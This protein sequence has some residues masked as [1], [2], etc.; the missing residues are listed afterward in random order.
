MDLAADILVAGGGMS[1]T[2]AAIAAARAGADVLLV[3]RFGFLGGAA[4]AAAV[5]QFVGWDTAAGRRVVA[6]LAEEVVARLQALGASDGH[7]HFTMSTGHRMDRVC[8]DPE[9]LKPV[10]DA[11]AAEAGVRLLFHTA[12]LGAERQGRAIASVDLLTKAG[13]CRVTPRLVIDASGDLDLL[14]RAGAAFLPL[15]PGQVMQPATAMFRF[16]P[17]DLPAFD[18]IPPITLAALAQQG[19]AEGRLARAALHASRIEGTADAWFNIGRL[20]FDATDPLALSAAEVEGR[21]Q[22][23]AAADFLRDLVPGCAAGRIQAFAPQVG[24][25]ESRR[26]H[27]LHVLEEAELRAGEAFADRIAWGA[28]PMDIHPAKGAGLHFEGFGADHAY[29]IPLRALL[30]RGF[31]NVLVA[32]R[33]ISASHKA[34]AA[35]RV[36]PIVMAIG[37]AAGIAAAMAARGNAAP[38][39]IDVASLQ[40]ALRQAGAHLP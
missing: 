33:G 26:I 6:G 19:V 4:T 8:Y 27:G 20:A 25:R 24:V 23:L 30:P 22:S 34:H 14:A 18:A 5:G 28:Y 12:I 37:Q 40:D 9:L 10:L 32:G 7:S 16:G 29:A 38:A 39:E 35:I 15:Q 31:D 17:I 21:R 3:E 2:M 1:G 11:M 36:M 13:V